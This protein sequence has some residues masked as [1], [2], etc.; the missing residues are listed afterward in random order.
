MGC[1]VE[2]L[3]VNSNDYTLEISSFNHFQTSP[4]FPW[5]TF[6]RDLFAFYI[7]FLRPKKVGFIA[8]LKQKMVLDLLSPQ[9]LEP[10]F[11]YQKHRQSSKF[12]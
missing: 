10:A 11:I 2:G 5:I 8:L 4:Q 12:L 9:L 7:I 1:L 3:Q 6:K